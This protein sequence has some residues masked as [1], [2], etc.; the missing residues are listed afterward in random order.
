VEL[1]HLLELEITLLH[2]VAV[3]EHLTTTVEIT[4]LVV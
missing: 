1:L 4:L 2:S 3:V